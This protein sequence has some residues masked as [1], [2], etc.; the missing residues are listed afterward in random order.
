MPTPGESLPIQEDLAITVISDLVARMPESHFSAIQVQ[1]GTLPAVA[2]S[3]LGGVYTRLL[4]L[5]KSAIIY[6]LPKTA[7]NW[8]LPENP[9]QAREAITTLML[10]AI[11]DARDE[12]R[13]DVVAEEATPSGPAAVALL[14]LLT[15]STPDTD[16][17]EAL[18]PLI[19]KAGDDL[20]DGIEMHLITRIMTG[21]A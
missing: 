8:E 19:R 14:E 7:L 18:R 5:T 2:I 6:Q 10:D 3:S 9:S 13:F 1:L 12:D 20:L 4:S 16:E 21:L 17:F 15:C 11:A